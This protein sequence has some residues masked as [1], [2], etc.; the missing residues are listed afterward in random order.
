[1][2][3]EVISRA[4]I[5]HMVT[6]NKGSSIKQVGICQYAAERI[7][8]MLFMEKEMSIERILIYI[9]IYLHCILCNSINAN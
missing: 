9:Y 4:L 8:E 1:M 7:D 3:F 2:Y 5:I 6:F